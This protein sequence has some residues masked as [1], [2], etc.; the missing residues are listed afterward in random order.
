MELSNKDMT[1]YHKNFK[2][3]T[4]YKILQGVLKK[5]P[6]SEISVD[7]NSLSKLPS[8]FNYSLPEIVNATD[9]QNSGRCWIFAGLN[10]LRHKLIH[11]YKL[12]PNFELSQSYL[13]KCDKLERCN[14]CLE[15][16]YDF[17]K[18]GRGNSTL[19]YISL[20]PSIIKDGGTWDMFVNLVN[21]YGCIPKSIYPESFQSNYTSKLNDMLAITVLKTSDVITAKMSAHEFRTYK[22][23]I[24]EECYRIINI[25]LGNTPPKFSWTFKNTKKEKIYT[26]VDFYIKTIKPLI[27]LDHYISICNYPVESYNQLLA[28]EYVHNV[29]TPED[30]KTGIQKKYTNVYLNIDMETFKESVFKNIKNNTAVWFACNYGQYTMNRGSILDE[31]S[32]NIKD[33]FDISFSLSKRIGLETRT[34]DPNHAM[35]F[36]GCQKDEDGI[37]RWKVENSHGKDTPEKG[38]ITMSDR[39][40]DDYVICAAVDINTLPVKMRELVKNKKNIK[41]LPYYSPLGTYAN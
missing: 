18:K 33:M 31:T 40:F 12:A 6:I 8:K 37:K 38:F 1:E 39:W 27:N 2:Q 30:I 26:P 14:Y 41:W 19:E 28:I 9:Q 24:M 16:I 11:H 20:I 23:T 4:K 15:L 7:Q 21:K 3:K 35:V 32:S 29:L 13:F 10:I 5:A 17:I 25:C 34:N 22:S 36:I